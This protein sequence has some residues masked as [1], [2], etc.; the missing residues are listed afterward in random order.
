MKNMT[1]LVF[2]FALGGCGD[3]TSQNKLNSGQ[4][5][6]QSGNREANDENE[7][8][9]S[10]RDEF[11]V[12]STAYKDGDEGYN[13]FRTPALVKA[14][15]G[16]LLAFA[17]GRKG[18]CGDDNDSDVVVRR[19]E[20][21]GRSWK[22]LQILD[23]GNLD[24]GSEQFRHERNR[25]GLVNPVVL[26]D[27][28]I[29]ILYL[30]SLHTKEKEDRGCRKVFQMTS[31][32][33]GATWSKRRDITSQAQRVCREDANG[34]YLIPKSQNEW[35]W[36]GLGPVHG[37]VKKFEPNKGR[38][39]I[40]GRHLADDNKTYSHVIYSDN[41]GKSWKIGGTLPMRSTESTVAE[42]RNGDVMV[43]SRS[44]ANKDARTVGVSK[45]GGVTFKPENT[46]VDTELIEPDGVQGSLL[47]FGK[48]IFFSNPKSLDGRTSGTIQVSGD[49]GESWKTLIK[50]TN[51][52][53]FS[54]YS[55]MVR[56]QGGI[57]LLFEWG[58][59][60]NKEDKHGRIRFVWLSPD[61]LS[62]LQQGLK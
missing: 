41:E 4:S 39:L 8:A 58:E 6:F 61:K 51:N 20:D 24:E 31:K 32:D 56:V 44:L 18:G 14:K 12:S 49:N 16:H 37:I 47:R 5:G 29:I 45:D 33:N 36:T 46:F 62:K 17:G 26:E 15:N 3:R 25:V 35:G 54:G 42:L 53:D 48:R 22:K 27:G 9:F 34:R 21:L 13:C 52:N 50:Y 59:S 10:K 2:L 1:V 19:S 57:G 55:D 7:L 28:T 43:N 23:K 30:W 60:L 38:I 11:Q 40:T